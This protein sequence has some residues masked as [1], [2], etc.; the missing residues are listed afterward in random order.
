MPPWDT[1]LGRAVLAHLETEQVLRMIENAKEDKTFDLNQKKLF[2]I[3]SEV[4]ENGFALVD[5]EHIKG[6]IA[7]AVPVFSST[8]VIGSI[9][10]VGEPETVLVEEF[11]SDYAPKLKQVGELLSEALGYRKQT[12]KA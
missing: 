8:G 10:M 7:I 2:D 6:I 5:Q 1:A 9:N 3:F 11:S 4:K 12:E